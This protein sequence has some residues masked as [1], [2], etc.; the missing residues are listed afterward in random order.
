MEF[1]TPFQI[2]LADLG[3]ER[4]AEVLKCKRRTIKSW[5]LGDR[6]PRPREALK[7]VARG[8]VTMDDIYKP[9]STHGPA[10]SAQVVLNRQ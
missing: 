4:A 6:F 5:R 2:Y 8:V 10:S 1:K 7:I 9:V 3:D